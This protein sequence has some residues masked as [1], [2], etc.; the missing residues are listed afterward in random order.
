MA[1][2]VKRVL[3][4]ARVL[5]RTGY[6]AERERALKAEVESRL[7]AERKRKNNILLKPTDVGG[8]YDFSRAL[9]TSMGGVRRQITQDDIRAFEKFTRD[10][11]AKYIK[12]GIT[13]KQVIEFSNE[14]DRERSNKQIFIAPLARAQQ[15]LL[16]FVTN[17]GPE[18]KHQRH[19]VR[20]KFPAFDAYAASPRSL[21]GGSA[22]VAKA[23]IEGP[24]QFD[25]DCE[26]HR[27][28]FRYIA[29]R[30]GFNIGPPIGRN[31]D[32]FPKLTNP[33][34]EGIACKHALRVMK[35]IARGTGIVPTVAKM[36]E[37][38]QKKQ[39]AVTL[40]PA[41][42]RAEA[43]RQLKAAHHLR[44]R[45]ETAAQRQARMSPQRQA[46]L[47]ALQAQAKIAAKKAEAAMSKG[48]KTIEKTLSKMAGMPLTKAQRDRLIAQLMAMHTTD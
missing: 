17:A 27:Y 47:K 13:A 24:L 21:D 34:L 40:S 37:V 3:N 19:I 16:Q 14:I 6:Q 15:G 31:E 18:S 38:A 46:A 28:V 35:Q 39:S 2:P 5:N 8:G 29:T 42:A 20:V 44:N 9:L 12:K 11:G 10:L 1:P 41:D 36:L 25:C 7:K 22:K 26:R 45:I 30:G 48:A 33:K 43:E 23:M 32:S 4:I